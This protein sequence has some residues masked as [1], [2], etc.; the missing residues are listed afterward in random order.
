MN[1][2]PYL[3]ENAPFTPAQQA[4]LNGFLAGL[5]ATPPDHATAAPP[6]KNVGIYYG[7]ESGNSEALAKQIAKAAREQGWQAQVTGLDQIRLADLAKESCALLV[8]S[9]FGDGEPPANA[10]AFREELFAPEAPGLANLHYSVLALG[11][12]NYEHFCQFGIELDTRL[13]ALGARRLCARVD[14]DVDYEESAAAWR[15]AAFEA[16]G[17][18]DTAPAIPAAPPTALGDATS[19]PASSDPSEETEGYSKK[20]PFP[21]TLLTN[22]KLTAEGSAKETRHLEI[23]LEGSGLRYEAGDALGVLPENCP[24]LIEDI[25]RALNCDGEEAVPTP[26]G[27]EVPLRTALLRHYEI[28]KIP[29]PLLQVVAERSSDKALAGLMVPEAKDALGEYLRGREIIDLLTGFSSVTFSPADFVSHL[30]RLQPRLYSIS[31]SPEAFPGQVHL[32]VATVRYESFGRQ[33]KGVCSTFLADRCAGSLPVYV[34]PSKSFRLPERDD[35]PVIMVGP[36][37][38]IAPFRAFLHE[39]RVRGATGK[40]WLFFGDQ[41]AATDFLY[42]EELEAMRGDGHLTRLD[43]AFSRDQKEKIYV[44]H[45]LL[46]QASELWAWLQDGAGFYVCG[47][48]ARM[49]RDVDA[50][51]HRVAEIAGGLSPEEASAY[52]RELKSEKRYLRDVY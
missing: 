30:R 4:W 44:Q 16:I 28:T 38:G 19:T 42:R 21:A 17:A 1:P 36:G 31:S 9:T 5:Y 51:L 24:A 29:T 35:T 10:A 20:R 6:A 32:T 12:T 41:K 47:D 43:T 8:T 15:K 33:R 26:E 52:V 25:L 7:S 34:H 50:A 3:P 14:C 39:R 45:R 49:A 18:L 37:T 2:A 46:E 48:A 11:D 27:G 23:S 13:E 22:R 40:N